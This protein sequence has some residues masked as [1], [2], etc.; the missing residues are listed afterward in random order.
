MS[1]TIPVSMSLVHKI[2]EYFD[3]FSDANFN[4]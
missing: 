4:V 3:R 1:D 2:F